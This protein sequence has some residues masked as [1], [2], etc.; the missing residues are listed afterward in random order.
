MRRRYEQRTAAPR[1]VEQAAARLRHRAI[2]NS[3]Y[4]GLEHRH[5][6]FGLTL[7]SDEIAWAPARS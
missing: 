1:V 6:A 4:A 7:I 3:R 5:V 2:L